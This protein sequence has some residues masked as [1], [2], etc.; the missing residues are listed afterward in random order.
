MPGKNGFEVLTELRANHADRW[1]P[2]IIVTARQELETARQCYQLDADHYLTKPC[3][4]DQVVK[5]V[6]TMI[7]LIPQRVEGNY[8][9]I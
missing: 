4:L 5:A 9:R 1:R 8:G 6:R 2:V 3:T 7:S